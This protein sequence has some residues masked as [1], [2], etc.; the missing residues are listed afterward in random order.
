MKKSQFT[1]SVLAVA[2]IGAMPCGA[3]WKEVGGLQVAPLDVIM[4]QVQSLSAKMKFP[5]L[6]MLVKEGIGQCES[7]QKYGAIDSSADWGGKFYVDGDKSAQ[8]WA[9]PVSGG[10][11]AWKKAH[12][13]AKDGEVAFTKD[14]RYACSSE[15]KSLAGKLAGG[16]LFAKPMK[17][18]FLRA[19]ISDGKLFDDLEGMLAESAKET[20][21][22]TGEKSETPPW[23]PKLCAS[24]KNLQR[25]VA[26]LGMS[27]SGLDIRLRATPKDGKNVDSI[28]A[29]MK[30]IGTVVDP[31]DKA[32]KAAFP[33][34]AKKKPDLV[35]KIADDPGVAAAAGVAP[36][37][38]W[39]FVWKDGTDLRA[40]LRI[41]TDEL[42]KAA[43]SMMQI[44]TQGMQEMTK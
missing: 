44:Q 1:L 24:V 42:A 27:K 23:Q 25:L 4:P 32:A 38:I 40:I 30:E 33:E 9:W 31:S 10:K 7:A 41:T 13:D 34:S 35:M 36:G 14:G 22:L 20:E 43:Q 17:K 2:M 3:E 19:T 11:A 37:N 16:E 15:E 28:L 39:A 18:G 5:L 26:V 12:P 29:V 8:A 21:K 6:P